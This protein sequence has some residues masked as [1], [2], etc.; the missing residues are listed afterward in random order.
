MWCASIPAREGGGGGVLVYPRKGCGVLVY[1]RKGG[2]V[3]VYPRKGCG[4]L[5][6]QR[7]TLKFPDPPSVYTV[8][9]LGIHLNGMGEPSIPLTTRCSLSHQYTHLITVFPF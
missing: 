4:V 3:L 9:Y 7:T 8:Q 6:S 1:T 2:G 5:V